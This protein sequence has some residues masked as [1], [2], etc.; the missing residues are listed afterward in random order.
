MNTEQKSPALFDGLSDISIEGNTLALVLFNIAKTAIIEL[1]EHEHT[2]DWDPYIKLISKDNIIIESTTGYPE[3]FFEFNNEVITT[4][5]AEPL[6]YHKD[7]TGIGIYTHDDDIEERITFYP[8]K[9]IR[10]ISLER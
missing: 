6:K 9:D 8:F 10:Y 2:G 3:I 5:Q 4:K 7:I 1:G